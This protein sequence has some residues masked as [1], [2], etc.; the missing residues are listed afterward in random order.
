M[1]LNV[2]YVLVVCWNVEVLFEV[3]ELLCACLTWQMSWLMQLCQNLPVPCQIWWAICTLRNTESLSSLTR[4]ATR[5][6][7]IRHLT[8]MVGRRRDIVGNLQAFSLVTSHDP[9]LSVTVIKNLGVLALPPSEVWS[10]ISIVSRTVESNEV[11]AV[12]FGWGTGFGIWLWGQLVIMNVDV[13]V[14]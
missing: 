10:F 9:L 2:S 11:Q 5:Y 12:C 6:D 13:N 3:M 1:L 4:S 8:Y 14:Q 7:H